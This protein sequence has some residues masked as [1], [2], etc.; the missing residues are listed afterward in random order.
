MESQRTIDTGDRIGR[1]EQTGV[2]Y[3]PERARDSHPMNVLAVYIGSNLTWAIVI[4]GW[5]PVA[6]GLNFWSA[7]TSV[8]VGLALGCIVMMPVAI[9]GPRTGTNMTVASGAHF[10]IRGRLIGSALALILAIV[11]AAQTVWTSGDAMVAAAHRMLGT[12]DG[13]WARALSYAL[14]SVGVVVAALYGHATIVAMQKLIVPIAGVLLLVGFFAFGSRFD[15][16]TTIADYSLGGYWQTWILSAVMAFAGAMSYVTSV[17]DYTR[18]ISQFKYGDIKVAGALGGG[19]FIGNLLP[20]V[21]GMFTAVVFVDPTDS[22]VSDLVNASPGWYVIP[23]VVIALIGGF[24]Q[25]VL[26][27]Y[28][29]GLDLEGLFPRLRR[30]QTTAIT[31]AIAVVLLYA[32]VFLV[33][34]VDSLTASVLVMNAV[35]VPWTAIMIIGAIRHRRSDYDVVD[36]QA[37]ADGR[38][39]G[40]YWYANGWNIPAVVAWL[41]GSVF[42]ILA[43]NCQLY[44]GPLADLAGG[45]DLSCVGSAAVTATIYLILLRLDSNDRKVA[46]HSAPSN[47]TSARPADGDGVPDQLTAK[48]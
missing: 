35:I 41:A 19:I 17:G 22:Y 10:G 12:S 24:G 2:E 13:N 28:S 38:R 31:A 37:F 36:L 27:L 5:L 11:Y 43:V 29:S 6:L 16:T 30:I 32:G 39:G 25:G 33:N 9:I 45:V 21:F 26:N 4:F 20:M 48:E 15:P 7:L 23:I 44:V 18:R 1:I 46:H 34:A 14:V 42:G 40:R 8:I 3:I 47:S